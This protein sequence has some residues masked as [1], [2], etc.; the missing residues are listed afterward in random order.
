MYHKHADG[1]SYLDEERVKS[2][3]RSRDLFMDILKADCA[4]VVVENPTPMQI[5]CLPKPTQIIQPYEFG[6][7]YTKR[8]LLW[9]RGVSALLPTEIVEPTK[10]S[11]VNG[12]ASA[13]RRKGKEN[14]FG[15]SSSKERARTFPGI[16]KAM[17]DQWGKEDTP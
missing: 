1:N 8:T 16:A 6:H 17:A 4:R 12:C 7:P 9:I 13:Y 3:I 2:M 14:I 5:A 10:G 15:V 11:W